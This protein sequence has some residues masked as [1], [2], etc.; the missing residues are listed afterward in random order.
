MKKIIIFSLF[1]F[2]CVAIASFIKFNYLDIP[3]IGAPY[4]Y[5]TKN[6]QDIIFQPLANETNRV[7]LPDGRK[8]IVKRNISASGARYTNEDETFVFWNKNEEFFIEENDIIIFQGY[9]KNQS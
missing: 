6:G 3:L 5:I 4:E 9:L 7:I 1:S 8:V 2:F